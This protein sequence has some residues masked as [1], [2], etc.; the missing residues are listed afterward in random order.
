MPNAP[1][2]ARF[3]HCFLSVL[4]MGVIA[5]FS[6]LMFRIVWPYTSG[7]LDID[8]L[9][10]KQHIIHFWHYRLAFYLHIFPALLVLTAGL[11]QFSRV[12]L[13]STPVVHRWVGRLYAWSILVVCGPAGMLMAWYANGGAVAKAS[14][15]TLSVLWWWTTWV[16]Y[17]A[18][19]AGN[20]RRHGAWMIRSYALT[21]SAVTLRMM[22]FGLAVYTDIDPET[23]YRLVAWP[24]W[25]LNL[26]AAEIV[27]RNTRWFTYIYKRSDFQTGSTGI[28]S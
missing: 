5:F 24:S 12:I 1:L 23:A 28:T 25:V 4:G 26:L 14:F 17:R 20:Y 11:T 3:T 19:R 8:F 15:L 16:A 27:L 9:L 10:S 6:F 2:P 7:R 22:Q 13:Q 21:L 18:I